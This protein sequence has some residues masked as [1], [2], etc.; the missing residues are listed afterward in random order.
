M[1]TSS[2]GLVTAQE[3]MGVPIVAGEASTVNL[4]TADDV[5]PSE[6]LGG[7]VSQISS[8]FERFVE[9]GGLKVWKD[10]QTTNVQDFD[11]VL[12]PADSVVDLESITEVGIFQTSEDVEV[13][14]VQGIWETMSITSPIDGDD[15]QTL[16]V[17]HDQMDFDGGTEWITIT[18]DT[19][20]TATYD[21]NGGVAKALDWSGA[22]CP[23]DQQLE[24]A[25]GMTAITSKTS[26]QPGELASKFV[27]RIVNDGTTNYIIDK[28][29][30]FA[31]SLIEE[32]PG[33]GVTAQTGVTL[34]IVPAGLFDV[35]AIM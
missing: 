12:F 8:T 31:W 14:S 15:M 7:L 34:A 4:A 19:G 9:L 33:F 29:G 6:T 10:G 23:T 17:L 26:A 25:F 28:S 13:E 3:M 1:M 22:E 16:S 30:D 20:T 11:L 18:S 5:L 21:Y 27:C 2:L 24:N 35:Y 32:N